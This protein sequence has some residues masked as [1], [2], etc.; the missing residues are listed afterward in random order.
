MYRGGRGNYSCNPGY[1]WRDGACQ[2]PFTWYDFAIGDPCS[3]EGQCNVSR[4]K[5]IQKCIP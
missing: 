4:E 3:T 1:L 5:G 2:L